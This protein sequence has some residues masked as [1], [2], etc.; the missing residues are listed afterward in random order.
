M[1]SSCFIISL[2]ARS[3][4]WIVVCVN[5]P[6]VMDLISKWHKNCYYVKVEWKFIYLFLEYVLFTDYRSQCIWFFFFWNLCWNFKKWNPLF[7][8][9]FC[10]VLFLKFPSSVMN[11]WHDFDILLMN[12]ENQINKWRTKNCTKNLFTNWIF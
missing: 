4:G 12:K 2:V 5:F 3:P 6:T 1:Y 7:T 8:L 9:D 10:I 11:V